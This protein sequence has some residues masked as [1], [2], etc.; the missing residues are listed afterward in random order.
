MAVLATA[1]PG[2]DLAEQLDMG[3]IDVALGVF[4]DVPSRFQSEATLQLNDIAVLRSGHPA[5]AKLSL[6][7]LGLSA[8]GGFLRACAGGRHRRLYPGT[9]FGAAIGCV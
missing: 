5:A 2:I 3:L 9:W 8:R 1:V 6:N 4:A 7:A